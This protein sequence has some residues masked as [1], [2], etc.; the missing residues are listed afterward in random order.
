MET[1]GYAMVRWTNSELRTLQL[2]CVHKDIGQNIKMEA[3]Q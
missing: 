1:K 2:D 3:K